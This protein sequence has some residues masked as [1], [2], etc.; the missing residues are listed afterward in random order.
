M[1]QDGALGANQRFRWQ[2]KSA[3]TVQWVHAEDSWHQHNFTIISCRSARNTAAPGTY[4]IVDPY[5]SGG[6]G[7]I[8]DNA[9]LRE[10]PPPTW[11]IAAKD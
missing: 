1:T 6:N 5:P 8:N 9:V 2:G 4:V 3:F 10:F 11:S 7:D